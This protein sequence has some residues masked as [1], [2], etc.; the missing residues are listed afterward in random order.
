MRDIVSGVLD[1]NAIESGKLTLRMD[2]H[3]A[4][5]LAQE[6]VAEYRERAAEKC[7]ALHLGFDAESLERAYMYADFTK[8]REV[9]ENLVSN[10][11]KYSPL[12]KHVFVRVCSDAEKIRFEVQDEGPG[13]SVEDQTKLF[14]RFTRLSAEPTAG[15]HSSG[16]GL[17]IAKKMMEAM[18]GRIWCESELG[19]GARFFVEFQCANAM[20]QKPLEPLE[21]A[22]L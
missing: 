3:D 16:L 8:A 17:S 22:F 10:A 19:R 1:L 6:V 18:N 21:M 20:E 7:I 5:I 14:Q 15:E 13:L 12:G 9:V 2:A 11:I 4:T